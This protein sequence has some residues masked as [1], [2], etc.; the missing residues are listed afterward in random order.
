MRS[1]FLDSTC[2]RTVSWSA[3]TQ[4]WRSDSVEVYMAPRVYGGQARSYRYRCF[5]DTLSYYDT[6]YD[7]LGRDTLLAYFNI[8]RGTPRLG[9]RIYKEW[10]AAGDLIKDMNHSYD[11][12]GNLSGG[13]GNMYTYASNRILSENV[14]INYRNGRFIPVQKFSYHYSPSN[15]GHDSISG[16]NIDTSGVETL[17]YQAT[18]I[19][20]F[21]FSR[22]LDS[23]KIVRWQNPYG[24]GLGTPRRI[25]TVYEPLKTSIYSNDI[26]SIGQSSNFQRSITYTLAN[27]NLRVVEV[28]RAAGWDTIQRT[29]NSVDTL[30]DGALLK[31][32]KDS[33]RSRGIWTTRGL[34]LT[35]VLYQDGLLKR[36]ISYDYGITGVFNP[37]Q[38]TD[39]FRANST[40]QVRDVANKMYA[41]YPNPT[42]GDADIDI[43]DANASA[44]V[45]DMMGRCVAE[46]Q[47]LEDRMHFHLGRLP[48]GLYK[49]VIHTSSGEKT[50]VIVKE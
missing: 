41:P 33:T 21:D 8:S 25:R 38:R 48:Q 36:T 40:T 39:Y 27:G 3:G 47:H 15:Q 2:Q 28:L 43:P 22:G 50:A 11:T 12:L 10:N 19:K 7:N 49:A 4:A 20:W 9:Y 1:P 31:L 30:P 34:S 35:Y 37:G 29:S 23:S 44:K 16:V 6:Y 18:D 5:G 13:G 26:D 46:G 45:F 24:P 17:Y 32:Y 14:V 42:S